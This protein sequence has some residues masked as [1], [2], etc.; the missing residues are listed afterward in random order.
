MQGANGKHVMAD[1]GRPPDLTALAK[2]FE[3][4]EAR[5]GR[6]PR[7]AAHIL[8]A[9][10]IACTNPMLILDDPLPSDEIVALFLDGVRG[11]QPAPTPV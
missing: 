3:S 1:K 11:H 8:R 7:A 2:I 6:D 9:I 4:D 10:T 5:I